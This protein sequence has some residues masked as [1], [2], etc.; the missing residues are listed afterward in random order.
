MVFAFMAVRVG[1]S[2]R[3]LQNETGV[4]TA[5]AERVRE[6]AINPC[7]PACALNVVEITRRVRCGEVHGRGQ[8]FLL[9]GE[10]ADGGLERAGRAERVTIVA[11]C[12]AHGNARRMV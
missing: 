10:C 1:G 7:W 2:G 6:H 9:K 8:P 12:A 4:D 5:E 11:L 3:A